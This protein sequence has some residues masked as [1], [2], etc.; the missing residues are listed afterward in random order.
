[1]IQA[2]RLQLKRTKK[3]AGFTLV[4]MLIY[5]GLLTLISTSALSL[6]LTLREL[7]DEYRAE[8][9]LTES[10]QAV[11]ER[12]LYEVRSADQIDTTDPNAVMVN[13]PGHLVIT[14][15]STVTEFYIS[16]GRLMVSVNSVELG[17][18]SK[19]TVVVNE[20]RFLPY[21]NGVTEAVKVIFSL[22]ANVGDA[23]A[24]ADFNGTAV[25]RGTYD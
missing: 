12:V 10:A 1:M 6:L 9:H 7:V 25:L 20:L 16:S 19:E 5:I 23:T 22:T 13:T 15:D 18:L 24:T 14:R 2:I 4:E 8:Q 17:P 21:D 3:M 11:L